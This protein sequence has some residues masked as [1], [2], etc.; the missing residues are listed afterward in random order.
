MKESESEWDEVILWTWFSPP[1]GWKRRSPPTLSCFGRVDPIT[2]W[3]RAGFRQIHR[4]SSL[5]LIVPFHLK[6]PHFHFGSNLSPHLSWE[7]PERG[8]NRLGKWN[9]FQR[10]KLTS[11]RIN[12]PPLSPLFS[13]QD[14]HCQKSRIGFTNR[15]GKGT[16]VAPG[17]PTFVF[18]YAMMCFLND[19]SG[20]YMSWSRMDPFHHT[21]RTQSIPTLGICGSWIMI[22]NGK[23]EKFHTAGELERW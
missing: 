1:W 4:Q 9:S 12:F 10:F 21:S 14:A 8:E 13:V 20:I 15:P 7:L 6:L 19:S 23:E 11:N 5:I 2:A 16:W 22:E 17:R 3:F 18:S